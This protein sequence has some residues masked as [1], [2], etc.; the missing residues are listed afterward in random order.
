VEPAASVVSVVLEK[1][2]EVQV[3]LVDWVSLQVELVDSQRWVGALSQA[4]VMGLGQLL[5]LAV[6]R[7]IKRKV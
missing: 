1:V 5:D 7:Q 6:H 4:V 2:Q 3:V